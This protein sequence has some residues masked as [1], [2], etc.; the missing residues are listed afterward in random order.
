MVSE[1]VTVEGRNQKG[2]EGGGGGEG[3]GTEGC[4]TIA[5][6]QGDRRGGEFGRASPQEVVELGLNYSTSHG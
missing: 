1:A 4:T 5:T 3:H 6:W 2:F